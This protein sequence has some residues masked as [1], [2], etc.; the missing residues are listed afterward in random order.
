MCQ[1]SNTTTCSGH[2][3]VDYDG[4]CDCDLGFQGATCSSCLVPFYVDPVCDTVGRYVFY[5]SC[6]MPSQTQHSAFTQTPKLHALQHCIAADTCS[7]HGSCDG[8][9]GLCTCDDVPSQN[10]FANSQANTPCKQPISSC[11]KRCDI[12]KADYFD[13][14]TCKYCTRR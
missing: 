3:I 9:T 8:T 12:C 6:V 2:G 7:G 4:N 1:F 14:P 10:A 11:A 5:L 13:Y